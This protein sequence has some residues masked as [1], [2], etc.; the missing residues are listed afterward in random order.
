MVVFSTTYVC[1]LDDCRYL[2][3]VEHPLS[4]IT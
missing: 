3:P 4:I 2:V 1:R